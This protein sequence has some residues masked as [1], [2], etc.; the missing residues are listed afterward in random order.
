MTRSTP[1]QPT[2]ILRY[3]ET[4]ASSS[5]TAVVETDAGEAYLKAINNPEGPHV[6]A[7]D[8]VGTHLARRFGLPTFDT[9]ILEIDDIDDIPIDGTFA[10]SGPAFVTRGEVGST[11]GGGKGLKNIENIADLPRL[12]V[13]D[14]WVRNCDRY[15]PGYGRDDKPRINLDNLFL[16][17]EGAPKGRFTL[18]AIVTDIS[19]PA[20]ED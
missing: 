1:W 20:A 4:V 18:K 3:T 12:V 2:T 14:T 19:L 6:L 17:T 15:G 9:A 7:C 5:R 13:F 11:M 8:W 10:S 16:S